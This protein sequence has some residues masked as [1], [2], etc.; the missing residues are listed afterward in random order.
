VS[1]ADPR[2]IA[3]L[4]LLERYRAQ[5]TTAEVEATGRSMSPTI[6]PRTRL[7]VEF[8]RTPDRIGELVLFRRRDVIVAHRLV[9]RRHV[10]G[11]VL[12]A[13]KGDG[14]AL[15]DPLLDPADALGVVVGARG[16]SGRLVPLDAPGRRDR[17]VALVSDLSGRT[18][19]VAVRALRRLPAPARRPAIGLALHLSRVPTRLVTA[20]TPGLTGELQAEGR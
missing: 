4:G 1:A 9:G 16:R 6:P 7:L 18:A 19:G 14:E 13:V 11:N 8:G 10:E 2:T 12:L 17:V 5:G 20:P 15:L 3:L